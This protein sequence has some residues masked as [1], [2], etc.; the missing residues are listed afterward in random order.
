MSKRNDNRVRFAEILVSSGLNKYKV[1]QAIGFPQCIGFMWNTTSVLGTSFDIRPDD[2]FRISYMN[3]NHSKGEGVFEGSD[4]QRNVGMYSKAYYEYNEERKKKWGDGILTI[5]ECKI[6]VYTFDGYSS[7]WQNKPWVL[8]FIYSN[9]T[10]KGVAGGNSAG[11]ISSSP[12]P[13]PLPPNYFSNSPT[14][15]DYYEN[16]GAIVPAPQGWKIPAFLIHKAA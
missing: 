4:Q 5:G 11:G 13:S 15:F 16:G 3:L 1:L 2:D 10:G 9:G 14:F 7:R 12:L 6:N 8:N